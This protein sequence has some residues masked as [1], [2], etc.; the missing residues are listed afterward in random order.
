MRLEKEALSWELLAGRLAS[1]TPK[2]YFQ[3]AGEALFGFLSVLQ[4]GV[5]C[6]E[7]RTLCCTSAALLL[8]HLITP[9]LAVAQS[10]Q[11]GLWPAGEPSCWVTLLSLH[12]RR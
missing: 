4:T 6:L 10:R 5:G 12:R 1:P 9:V 8:E 3:R 2:A 7:Y 11:G